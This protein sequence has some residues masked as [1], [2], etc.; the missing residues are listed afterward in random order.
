MGIRDIPETWQAFARCLDA[1]EREHFGFDAGARRVAESTL[2]LLATFP[3]NHRLPA[4]LVRRISLATMDAP[5]LDAF[6]FP[7]PPRLLSAL[8][9]AALKARGRVVRFLPPRTEPCF[10]RQLPQIR[11]YPG[12][13]AVAALGTFPS[14]CP[15]PH[16]PA[17]AS[18]FL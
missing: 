6:R 9:R 4:A 3:P 7:H 8:V 15:V 5:L 14:G 13:Y 10:A 11:S 1:Y 12:G 18:A 16:R 17:G 2:A